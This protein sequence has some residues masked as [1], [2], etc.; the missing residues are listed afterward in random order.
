MA[1][2]LTRPVD[3]DR[4]AWHL[5]T[6]AVGADAEAADALAAAA[7]RAR[8]RSG[9]GAAS[10]GFER[11]A[12][13]STDELTRLD[14]LAQAAESAWAG[15]AQAR[16][17]GLV[18]EALAAAQERRLCSRLQVLRGRIE[19][20]AGVLA[21][22]RDRIRKAASLIEDLDP[23]SAALTLNY[24]VFCCH[25]EGLIAEGLRV[26]RDSRA[27]V[28]A[29]GSASDTRTDYVLGR[30]L[31]LAGNREAGAPLLE[32]MIAPALGSEVLPRARLAAAA[33]C[34]SVLERHRE[35][36]ELVATVLELAREEG[37]MALAYAL[38]LSAETELR[39][40]RRR[41]AV[42]SATE[43]LSLARELG[44]SNIAATFLVVL[45]RAEAIR[46][47]EAGFRRHAE[48]ADGVLSAAGM[49]LPLTQ[50]ACGRGLLE[51]GVGRL[52]DAS[53]TLA[54]ASA[55]AEHM[56]VFDGDV[57]PEPDLVE[58]LVRLGRVDEARAAL[59]AWVARGV[60]SQLRLGEALA[61][62]CRG[63]LA[64]DDG[65]AAAFSQAIEGHEALED[66]FGEART[67]LCLGERLRRKGLRVDARRELHAALETF[68]R[69]EAAPWVERARSELRASGERLRRREEARDELTPQELQ[70]VLQVAEGKA[71][72]EVAAAL[73]LS[74]KTVE[75]HLTR[76]YRKL[77]VSSRAE[78]ILRFAG[79]EAAGEPITA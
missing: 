75:F 7:A 27:I 53:A 35:S 36:R 3:E 44:Q 15:G 68:E 38:S 42:A 8:E 54:E 39:G 28:P 69:L 33:T 21:E 25:F 16:A 41:R 34:L 45:A 60:P 62:R 76:I 64:D 23:A 43:G 19:L 11:A 22:A 70:V 2:V 79:A 31:L 24:V 14:R 17:V 37:P 9:F 47:D 32:R 49:L 65:F 26:A 71:N 48:E 6:A 52:D 1:D 55:V 46:G 56:A 50:V 74:P 29:D 40:G 20:Q 13:L 72:K 58:T 66:S 73:F 4:R 63:L 12:R 18:E 59:E 30:S 5:A 77:D 61:A 67:R 10:A 78:V 57:L 51:L